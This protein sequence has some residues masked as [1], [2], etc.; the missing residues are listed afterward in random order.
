MS[1][2]RRLRGLLRPA[3]SID[4]SALTPFQRAVVRFNASERGRTVARLTHTLGVPKASVGALAG[5]PDEVRITVAWE[6]SWYQWGVDVG[7]ETRPVFE[8]A[9]GGEVDQLDAAARQWNAVV[10]A[11]GRL[12]LA[13]EPLASR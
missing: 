8:I 6:L 12:R 7:D 5:A 4:P 9:K 11:D 13:S 3:P 1:G 10:G 2:R